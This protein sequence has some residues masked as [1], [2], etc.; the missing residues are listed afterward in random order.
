MRIRPATDADLPALLTLHNQAIRDN[1]GIWIEIEETLEG[2]AAWLAERRQKGFPVVV[3]VNAQDEVLGYAAYGT[4]RGRDGYDLTVEHSVYLFPE[5]HGKGYGRQLL[6]HIIELAR[7]DGRHAMVAVIDV[8]NT[9]SIRLHRGFGFTGGQVLPQL[10]KKR[11]KWRD[12]VQMVLL[13]DDRDVP[14]V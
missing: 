6:A 8:E 4:Y 13:L 10:G 3:G 2:R 1:D 7:A 11:G 14:P 12:Q 9:G 5:H